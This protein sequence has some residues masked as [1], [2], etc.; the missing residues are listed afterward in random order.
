MDRNRLITKIQKLVSNKIDGNLVFL[1]DLYLET[2]LKTVCKSIAETKPQ[3]HEKLLVT[4]SIAKSDINVEDF[5]GFDSFLLTDLTYQPVIQDRFSVAFI[6]T[7]SGRYKC[8]PVRSIPSL[9]LTAEHDQPY[10]FIE[11]PRVFVAVNGL[12]I[13]NFTLTHYIYATIDQFP[14]ELEEYLIA[15]LL[16]LFPR[17]EK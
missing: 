2:A 12:T 9:R 8:F 3:G 16:K 1:L 10:Y 5:D 14:E 7:S 13:T 15:E 11:A 17:N 4:Q 6:T